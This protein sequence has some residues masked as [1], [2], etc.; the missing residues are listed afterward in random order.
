MDEIRRFFESA[1]D[2]LY[3]MRIAEQIEKAQGRA[4]AE[5]VAD[6]SDWSTSVREQLAKVPI[7]FL[8]QLF[9]IQIS[10]LYRNVIN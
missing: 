8:L 5:F 10:N 4:K 7:H 2:D 6:N 9:I 1:A 3:C